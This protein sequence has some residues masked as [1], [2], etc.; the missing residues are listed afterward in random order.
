MYTIKL[1]DLSVALWLS[2]VSIVRIFILFRSEL[3][4]CTKSIQ[5][6]ELLL[7]PSTSD[8]FGI[9]LFIIVT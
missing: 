4:K 3:K 5:Q 1:K 7:F 8:R 2:N 6:M 9:Q